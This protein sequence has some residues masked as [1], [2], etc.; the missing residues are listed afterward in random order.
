MKVITLTTDFGQADSYVAEMKG[1]MLNLFSEVQFIDITHLIPPQDVLFGHLVLAQVWKRFP[2][3]TI[4]LGVVDP[5]V[6]T[7]RR[8][9]VC[10]SRGHIFVGPDNGLF[11]FLLDARQRNFWSVKETFRS[12]SA[13]FEGRDVFSVIVGKIAAGMS[14]EKLAEPVKT[15]RNVVIPVPEIKRS[16]AH[17]EVITIDRFGNLVTNFLDTMIPEH[18]EV[19]LG[20]KEI[21]P[22]LRTYA[23]APPGK[24]LALWNSANRLEI[25][26]R[27]GS[28]QQVLNA[29]RGSKVSVRFA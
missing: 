8:R 16:V 24:P 2:K 15:I 19:V 22:I 11:G 14:L 17:G 18:G 3:G 1:V 10:E 4:H 7:A 26:V 13:T 9:I 23:D 25:A 28:A 6:G 29:K 5:G 27:N 20:K 21:G 12:S